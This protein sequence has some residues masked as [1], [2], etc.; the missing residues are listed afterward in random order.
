MSEL[1]L[2]KPKGISGLLKKK[3]KTILSRVNYI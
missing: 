2:K 1:N 3:K